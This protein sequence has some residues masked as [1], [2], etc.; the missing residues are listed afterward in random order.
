MSASSEGLVESRV[1]VS[2]FDATVSV[3]LAATVAHLLCF[4]ALVHFAAGFSVTRMSEANQ[5]RTE[6][7]LAK[8]WL[9]P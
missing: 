7:S 3:E 2:A 6:L 5:A 9:S 1:E 4:D 8:G